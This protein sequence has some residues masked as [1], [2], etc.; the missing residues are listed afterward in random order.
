MTEE[1]SKEPQPGRQ[2]PI[3]HE[4]AP[5]DELDSNVNADDR[6]EVQDPDGK[7]VSPAKREGESS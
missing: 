6:V 5:A 1:R 3:V 2:R 4:G 7:V